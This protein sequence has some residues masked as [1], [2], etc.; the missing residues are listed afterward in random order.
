MIQKAEIRLQPPGS[1]PSRARKGSVPLCLTKSRPNRN[2]PACLTDNRNSLVRP[3]RGG[4]YFAVTCS[5]SCISRGPERC[6]LVM[7]TRVISDAP[8]ISPVKNVLSGRG[9]SGRYSCTTVVASGGERGSQA[10]ATTPYPY[11]S[12]ANRRK[13]PN[14]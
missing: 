12:C 9:S 13:S 7:P 5:M 3:R 11:T 14:I 4:S 10:G 6:F 8:S 1:E 2:S